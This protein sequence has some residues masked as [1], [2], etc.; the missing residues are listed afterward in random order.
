M[1]EIVQI[2]TNRL[3][4]EAFTTQS[5]V[6]RGVKLSTGQ[7]PQFCF[8]SLP[9]YPEPTADIIAAS[10][11]ESTVTRPAYF[12]RSLGKWTATPPY[13]TDLAP[14]GTIGRPEEG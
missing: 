10:L 2:E 14:G 12:D 9:A 5:V 3:C 13:G 7:Q 6:V 4:E 8:A 11:A 1:T